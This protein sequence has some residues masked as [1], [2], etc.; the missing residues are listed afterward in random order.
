MQTNLAGM[1]HSYDHPQFFRLFYVAQP[2]L[3]CPFAFFPTNRM[4]EAT[5]NA[6]S[7]FTTTDNTETRFVKGSFCKSYT[8]VIQS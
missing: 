4:K 2:L 6:I 5:H 8:I 1:I 7:I 3:W